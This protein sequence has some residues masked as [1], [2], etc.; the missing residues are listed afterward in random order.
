MRVVSHP[1]AEQ[2]LEA[3][4][5][6]YDHQQSGLGDDFLNE[7]DRNGGAKFR[8]T[9]ASSTSIAFHTPSCTACMATRYSS[10]P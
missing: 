9:T 6:W 4:V 8:A 5:L 3:A 7:F 2:E 1:E 10:K